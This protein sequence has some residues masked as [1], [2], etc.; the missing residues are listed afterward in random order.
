MALRA[1]CKYFTLLT[2]DVQKQCQE[3]WKADH[4]VQVCCSSPHLLLSEEESE[5]SDSDNSNPKVVSL[6]LEDT[7]EGG[8]HLLYV[9]LWPEEHLWATGTT[10]QC[11]VEVSQKHEKAE[12]KIPEYLQE[13]KSVFSKEAFDALPP[14]KPWDHAIELE[15]GSKPTNCKVYL[16]SP[17]E[18]VELDAFLKENLR[19]RKIHLSK[20]PMASLVFFI[21]K[22][23]GLLWLIQGYW[24]LNCQKLLSDSTHLWANHA[25]PRCQILHLAGCPMG[26]QQCLG[27]G[28]QWVEGCIPHQPRAL[29]ATSHVLWPY[30]QPGNLPDNDEW[31][32][33]WHDS[34]R[35]GLCLPWWYSHLHQDTVGA[36]D[37]HLKSA[38][39]P[40]R[41]QLVPQ[42]REVRIWANLDRISQRNCLRGNCGD[43]S[44]KSVW[45]IGMAGA[46]EQKRSP[47]LCQ[48]CKLLPTVHQ[49]LLSSYTCPLQL[50]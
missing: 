48:I 31:H 49:G 14:Q 46:S 30:K 8:E 38:E 35:S 15:P 13:F 45:S 3:Q 42:A 25:T 47:V 4:L 17:K 24:A 11:L 34:R 1:M 23:D 50:H 29:W 41:V 21:K 37:N 39:M 2:I 22:K 28:R 27:L 9:N 18:Q 26:F 32:F 6:G 40:L 12:E 10:S 43:G 5:E 19:T 16:L 33:P 20:S 44:S 7:L 36:S